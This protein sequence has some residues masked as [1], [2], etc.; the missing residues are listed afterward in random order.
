MEN[1]ANVLGAEPQP[2]GKRLPEAGTDLWR[3]YRQLRGVAEAVGALLPPEQ[4]GH[5]RI[6]VRM[7]P[8]LAA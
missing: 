1:E 4:P 3:D 6:E 7:G 8:R 2:G 5:L